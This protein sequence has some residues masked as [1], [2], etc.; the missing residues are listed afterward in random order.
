MVN[1]KIQICGGMMPT[2]GF[3]SSNEKAEGGES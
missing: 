1:V 2:G 3:G